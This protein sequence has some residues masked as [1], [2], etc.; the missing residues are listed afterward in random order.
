TEPKHKHLGL[1]AFILE[2]SM[3]GLRV[4][5]TWEKTGLRTSPTSAV[6]CD[7]CRVPS[8]NLLGKEGRGA[9]IFHGSMLWERACLFAAYIGL[10]QRQLE[11][12]WE[13]A[14]TRRQFGT[15]IIQN[16]AVSQRLADMKIRLESSRLLLYRACWLTDTG[17]N[18][19]QEIAIA[20]LAV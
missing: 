6:Y 1:S 15:P 9:A 4:G 3:T 18:A 13:H 11:Q 5:S 20:K 12:V 14:K 10:L 7:E 19:T 16:Q 2:K 8:C 17:Q